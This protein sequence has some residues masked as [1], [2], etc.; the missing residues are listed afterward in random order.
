[1]FKYT[2]L[3]IEPRKHK[4]FKY[5]IHNFLENLSEEWGILVFHGNQNKDF[6]YDITHNLEDRYKRRIIHLINLNVDN[7]DSHSYSNV[8]FDK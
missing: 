4:A 3:I 8:F 7:L 1:M 6:V 5:V 2:A